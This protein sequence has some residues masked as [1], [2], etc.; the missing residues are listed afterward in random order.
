[1][2]LEPD[3]I[4]DV[5][6]GRQALDQRLGG[7]VALRQ[8]IDANGAAD[9]VETLSRG[10]LDQHARGPIRA[11]PDHPRVSRHIAR[12]NAVTDHRPVGR[13]AQIGLGDATDRSERQRRCRRRQEPP[14]AEQPE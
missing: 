5:L 13:A 2:V 4:E 6:P 8:R 10:H 7:E 14:T 1:M 11:C 12:L 3:P 9:H